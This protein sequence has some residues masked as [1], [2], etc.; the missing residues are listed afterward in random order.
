MIFFEPKELLDLA[1]GER[2]FSL[3]KLM[4]DQREEGAGNNSTDYRWVSRLTNG[5]VE[6]TD[7][8]IIK[9]NRLASKR[10]PLTPTELEGM[11]SRGLASPLHVLPWHSFIYGADA[12]ANAQ[13]A[14]QIPHTLDLVFKLD[15][16][17]KVAK[18]YAKT[19]NEDGLLRLVSDLP[20]SSSLVSDW[21]C[22]RLKSSNDQNW[23]AT[24]FP[25]RVAVLFATLS[26]MSD[27]GDDRN[28]DDRPLVGQVFRSRDKS[29]G[30][31]R[32]FRPCFERLLELSGESTFDRLFKNT[33]SGAKHTRIRQGRKYMAAPPN[34]PKAKACSAMIQSAKSAYDLTH[35]AVY[36]I[37]MMFFFA[38]MLTGIYLRCGE[39][40][41]DVSGLSPNEIMDEWG[42]EWRLDETEDADILRQMDAVLRH[43]QSSS[44]RSSQS[45][46]RSSYPRSDQ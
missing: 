29:T 19:G 42:V 27:E 30:N 21:V 39:I 12:V 11:T 8:N 23:D 41:N 17:S 18:N 2:G 36:E 15:I 22:D 34:N 46:G 24:F 40:L 43:V 35:D 45:S 38:R 20:F 6:L 33:L 16:L 28:N 10:L 13:I 3:P 25:L 4:L 44:D 26:H 37:S 9:F 5:E 1:E 31:P 7:K 32:P 14:D